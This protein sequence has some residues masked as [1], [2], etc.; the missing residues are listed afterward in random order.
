MMTDPLAVLTSAGCG[1]IQ[2][3][4][5]PWLRE[6]LGPLTDLHKGV[7]VHHCP[8]VGPTVTWDELDAEA[9]AQLAL[10]RKRG[11]PRLA[12]DRPVSRMTAWRRRKEMEKHRLRTMWTQIAR[13]AQLTQRLSCQRPAN[14]L[15]PS[16]HGQIRD[17]NGKR[18]APGSTDNMPQRRRQ[19]E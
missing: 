5:F 19:I 17:P 18:C 12:S 10:K 1:H 8:S 14:L 7:I 6:E 13:P 15:A 11:R 16:G 3:N 9:Q 2:D 4:L